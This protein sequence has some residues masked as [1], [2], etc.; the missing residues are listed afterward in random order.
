MKWSSILI[1]VISGH[2]L[3]PLLL[4]GPLCPCNVWNLVAS[5]IW[6]LSSCYLALI[7]HCVIEFDLQCQLGHVTKQALVLNFFCC[8]FLSKIS[9]RFSYFRVKFWS[10]QSR[11]LP[12]CV[13]I[14]L[15]CQ[16]DSA[17]SSYNVADNIK[18]P[19]VRFS[20]PELSNNST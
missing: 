10:G 2:V 6:S 17:T 14:W 15:S 9:V 18:G 3:F 1:M 5:Y 20:K 19:L 12:I 13:C 16:L 7:F 11:S 4:F 8:T